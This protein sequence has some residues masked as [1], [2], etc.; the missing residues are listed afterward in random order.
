MYVNMCVKAEIVGT[1]IRILSQNFSK[2]ENKSLGK[3][4]F[5]MWG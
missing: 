3:P 5:Y 4:E 1:L 2:K